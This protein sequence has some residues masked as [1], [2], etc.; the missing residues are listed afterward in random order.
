MDC[1]TCSPGSWIVIGIFKHL[2]AFLL[3][4]AEFSHSSYPTEQLAHKLLA[5]RE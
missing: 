5:K 4:S 2:K 3:R 1:G